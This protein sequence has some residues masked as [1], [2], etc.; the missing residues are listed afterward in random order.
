MIKADK[1]HLIGMEMII[2]VD[3]LLILDMVSGCATSDLA[4]LRC[5]AYIKYQNLEIQHISEKDN[6]MADMLSRARYDDKNRIMVSEDKEVD[7]DVFESGPER[8]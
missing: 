5:I 3:Y 6:A 8:V 2:E 1:E 7:K 4:M